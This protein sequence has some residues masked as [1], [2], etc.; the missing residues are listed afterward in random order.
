MKK[1]HK[2]KKITIRPIDSQSESV[3]FQIFT[4]KA[5]TR[6]VLS[7]INGTGRDIGQN[8]ISF[9]IRKYRC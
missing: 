6:E 1:I 5:E 7:V 8:F 4:I 9:K 3:V 2:Y